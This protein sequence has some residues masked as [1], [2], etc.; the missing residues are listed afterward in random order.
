MDPKANLAE[1]LVSARA[2]ERIRDRCDGNGQVQPA[3]R[4]KLADEAF[5]LGELVETLHDWR[6]K[7]GYDPY[8]PASPQVMRFLD[9]STSHLTAREWHETITENFTDL[10]DS[11]P[12]VIRHSYGAWV[13]VLDPA[14]HE[15]MHEQIVA[16]YPNV[17]ACLARARSYGCSWINFDQDAGHEPGLP[18]FDW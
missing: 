4:E 9:L 7:G 12:R 6:R 10:D 15:E 1:Q 16:H 17:A 13:N 3:D 18:T 14:E 8:A 11:G 2:I 5:T